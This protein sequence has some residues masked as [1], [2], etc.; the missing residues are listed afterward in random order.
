MVLYLRH[1]EHDSNSSRKIH[2]KC[3]LRIIRM[4]FLY[5]QFAWVMLYVGK[6]ILIVQPHVWRFRCWLVKR[7][8][9]ISVDMYKFERN[10]FNASVLTAFCCSSVEKLFLISVNLARSH[11]WWGRQ[12]V[13][14]RRKSW[15]HTTRPP[16]WSAFLQE[17]YFGESVWKRYRLRTREV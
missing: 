1:Y 12:R 7:W 10:A 9:C 3:D 16:T 11:R 13:R 6:Y 4:K 14:D 5:F 2:L 15:N 17:L 8:T